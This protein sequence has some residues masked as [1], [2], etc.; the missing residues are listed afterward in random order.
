MFINKEVQNCICILKIDREEALNAMNPTGLNELHQILESA[1]KDE[2]IGV[3]ILIGSGEKAFIA[4]A[5][6]KL[7][8]KL[9][10]NAAMEFGKLGQQVANTI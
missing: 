2:D 5:D 7:M 6:I 1:I 10:K 9:D 8:E 4:G 3:I